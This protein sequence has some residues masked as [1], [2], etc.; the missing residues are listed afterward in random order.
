MSEDWLAV[1]VGLAIFA[2]AFG[3]LLRAD[4][5]GLDR[6]TCGATTSS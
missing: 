1:I 2:L 3:Y 6:P 5:L 4:L